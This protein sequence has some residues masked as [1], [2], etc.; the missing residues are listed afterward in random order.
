MSPVVRSTVGR[1]GPALFPL[2]ALVLAFGLTTLI[3]SFFPAADL[4]RP[5][6]PAP[7]VGT[8][9]GLE[10]RSLPAGSIRFVVLEGEAAA[11]DPDDRRWGPWPQDGSLIVPTEPLSTHEVCVQAP[12]G[13][14]VAVQAPSRPAAGP[15]SERTRCWGPWTSGNPLPER[16]LFTVD[17]TGR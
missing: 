12:E 15:T 5:P 16:V 7:S 2:L 6:V 9:F 14:R 13:W 1:L 8:A 11:P 17:G 4:A 10:S 3:G